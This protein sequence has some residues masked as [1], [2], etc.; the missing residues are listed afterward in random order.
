MKE[1]GSD[2]H[3]LLDCFSQRASLIDI[4]KEAVCFATGRHPIIALIQQYNWKRIWMPYYF[5]YEVILS[6]EKAGIDIA[7][8]TDYPGN[9][10]SD[11]I[12]KIKFKKGDVLFR[13]NYFGLRSKRSNSNIPVPVIEDH[14]HDLLS[15]WALYSDA[16]WCIASLRK[17]L[18]LAEGGMAWSP[19]SFQFQFLPTASEANNRMAD[20]RW[21]GMEEKALYLSGTKIDKTTFREKYISTEEEIDT[22]ELSAISD[23]DAEYL[24]K[25]DINTW[26]NRKKTNWQHIK[27]SLN[28]IVTLLEPEYAE[29][30]P[31]SAVFLFHDNIERERV[32]KTLIAK[33]VYPAVLWNI[34]KGHCEAA[35]DISDRM[36]SI[37]CD[38]R[39]T[40]RNIDELCTILIS[41]INNDTNF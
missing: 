20:L 26:Y 9:N 10:D 3:Y 16:D 7:F 35:R 15:N 27:R 4:Y 6:I 36:L 40:V 19:K 34:P 32:R 24:I 38:G 33:C 25:L 12:K 30:Y 29:G 37:H 41:T 28:G 11:I 2:F 8:Y 1:F 18:P 21:K 13:V 39:Y 31:F 17:S 14:S 22:L 23:R 5:C